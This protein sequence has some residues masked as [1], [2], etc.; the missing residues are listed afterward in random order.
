[1]AAK[2]SVKKIIFIACFFKYLTKGERYLRCSLLAH[3]AAVII[4]LLPGGLL[5]LN[6]LSCLFLSDSSKLVSL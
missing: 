1:M 5:R 6:A 4:L 3:E 2:T